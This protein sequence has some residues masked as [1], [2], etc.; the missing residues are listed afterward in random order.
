MSAPTNDMLI[1]M[2]VDTTEERKLFD[3]HGRI[4]SVLKKTGKTSKSQAELMKLALNR[5]NQT[6]KLQQQA[7]QGV[8]QV[9]QQQ[10]GVLKQ[11]ADQTKRAAKEG[12]GYSKT[13]GQMRIVTQGLRRDIGRLRNQLLLVTFT[14]QL[15]TRAISPMIKASAAQELA[16]RKLEAAFAGSGLASKRHVKNLKDLANQYQST[17]MFGDEQIINAQAMLGT[18]KLNAEQV[19]KLTPRL[20]DMATAVSSLSGKEIDLQAIAIAVGKGFTGNVGVLSRYGVVLSETAKKSKDFNLLLKEFDEN[21]KGI[22]EAMRTTYIGQTKMLGNVFGD[23]QE[24]VGYTITKSYVLLASLEMIKESM[25]GTTEKMKEARKETNNFANA[26]SKVILF[27]MAVSAEFK[28]FWRLFIKGMQVMELFWL[29]SE[30]ASMSITDKLAKAIRDKLSPELQFAFDL[31]RNNVMG[32]DPQLEGLQKRIDE[33]AKEL[34]EGGKDISD[35][36]TGLLDDY[37]ALMVKAEEFSNISNEVMNRLQDDLDGLKDK[38]GET[39]DFMVETSDRVVKDIETSLSGL[40]N[41]FFTKE[42]KTAADYFDAFTKLIVKSF[43]DMLAKMLVQ[44]ATWT[45]IMALFN[46]ASGGAANV[47]GG[48]GGGRPPV[49][50][51]LTGALGHAGG[52]VTQNRIQRFHSG[53]EIPA[54]L[55]S[56]EGVVSRRGMS[57]LGREGLEKINRGEGAGGSRITNIWNINTI[58]AK[59]FRQYLAENQDIFISS[60]YGDMEGNYGL[61]K[62][63]KGGI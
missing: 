61:R 17:T 63:F 52:F 29:W 50:S 43:A 40:F 30:K 39:F 59:S 27:V 47:L 1:K 31:I 11:V 22:A 44:K 26:W 25:L 34:G 32:I 21:Y 53:G 41:D 19:G 24:Q 49:G 2:R 57:G 8:T 28:A 56:G 3:S 36:W 58:D 7:I 48:I 12:E 4:I 13:S 37:E 51:G 62:L 42:L 38:T 60:V 54:I 46:I 15:I 23:L 5:V 14:Y 6:L 33:L 9:Q 16:E 20:L 18:F 10:I 35:V 45:A 55:Q